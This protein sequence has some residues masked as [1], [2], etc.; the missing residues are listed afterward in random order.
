MPVPVRA[1]AALRV[2]SRTR[3]LHIR[4]LSR[5]VPV[6]PWP[7]RRA[8]APGASRAMAAAPGSLGARELARAAGE[9]GSADV[10]TSVPCCVLVRPGGAGGH[11]REWRA[12]SGCRTVRRPR[13]RLRAALSG[14]G[15]RP[16]GLAGSGSGRPSN[17]ACR[18]PAGAA[19]MSARG[20][21]VLGQKFVARLCAFPRISAMP[22]QKCPQGSSLDPLLFLAPP[23]RFPNS[24]KRRT[25]YRGYWC[26]EL[27]AGCA[28]F[29]G[30]PGDVASNMLTRQQPCSAFVPCLTAISEQ[31]RVAVIYVSQQRVPVSA[32]VVG[33]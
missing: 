16:S 7:P 3:T 21:H 11:P 15:A 26:P 20:P 23:G 2:G 22:R 17:R 5:L 19:S 4:L 9:P 18:C 33:P 14:A 31:Q 28:R 32:R 29:S 27:K 30:N 13:W 10:R 25:S 24:Y 12:R 6:V 8:P 1:G